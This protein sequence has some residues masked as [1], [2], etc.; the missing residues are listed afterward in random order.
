MDITNLGVHAAAR[1]GRVVDED[2]LG[3]AVDERLHVLQIGL[4]VVLR[5]FNSK[6][7]QISHEISLVYSIKY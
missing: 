2:R 1:V 5:L 6:E 7:S 3:V 4:P